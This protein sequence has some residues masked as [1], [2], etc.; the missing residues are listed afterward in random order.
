METDIL[1]PGQHHTVAENYRQYA[2]NLFPGVSDETIKRI[3]REMVSARYWE[4]YDCNDES[5]MEYW[6]VVK[7]ILD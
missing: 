4:A 2:S 5:R 6:R 7:I 1:I 3:A